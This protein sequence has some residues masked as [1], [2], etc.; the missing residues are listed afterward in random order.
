M[1]KR[2]R[3]GHKLFTHI[4]IH[5]EKKKEKRNCV[6]NARF[7]LFTNFSTYAKKPI[8]VAH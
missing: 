3:V 5:A 8:K 7:F 1:L 2:K 4:C 6:L